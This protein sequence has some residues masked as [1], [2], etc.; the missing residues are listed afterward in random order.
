MRDFGLFDTFEEAEEWLLSFKGNEK[1][2]EVGQVLNGYIGKITHE[3]L[4]IKSE[5]GFEEGDVEERIRAAI[6]MLKDAGLKG[7]KASLKR[8]L[9]KVGE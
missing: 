9:K 6:E 4:L 2:F 3:T 1:Y 7:S 5:G 8:A